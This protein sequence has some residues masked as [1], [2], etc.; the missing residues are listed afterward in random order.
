MSVVVADAAPTEDAGHVVARAQGQHSNLA[1]LLHI[2]K[3]K[4][5]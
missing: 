4:R 3:K 1:L 5:K 2:A